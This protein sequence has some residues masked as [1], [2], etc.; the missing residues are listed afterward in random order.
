MAEH[1]SVVYSN[2]AKYVEKLLDEVPSG[3]DLDETIRTLVE[4]A[5]Q[6]L[7]N[8][9]G[10]PGGRFYKRDGA[11][12]QLQ[13]VFGDGL[14]IEDPPRLKADYPPV[15]VCCSEGLVYFQ[16]DDPRLDRELE[17]S[18][19]A[20][21]FAAIEV[22]ERDYLLAFDLAEG[23]NREET[24]VSLG[25]LRSSINQRVRQERVEDVF[26]EARRIQASL[27][28]RRMPS[29][30]SF[31]FAGRSDSVDR[32]GGDFYDFIPISKKI[33]G[34]TV[35]DVSGHGLPAALQ[36][37]DIYMGLRMGLG[38]DYKIVRTMERLSQIIHRSTLT[39]R[40]VSLFYGE[41]ELNGN[42]LYVNA[43]HPPPFHL[44]ADGEVTLLE[45][46]GVVMGPLPDATYERGY[47]KLGPGDLLV[48]YTDG[49]AE[50]HPE[51]SAELDEYGRDRLIE[52]V[53]SLRDSSA[54]DI[55]NGIFADVDK[56]TAGST[57]SD[58]RTV[59]VARYP[60]GC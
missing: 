38:R 36:V 17:D 34:L 22:G 7:R 45:E 29:Y 42:F 4:T 48:L 21:A 59:C 2:L 35:A 6:G 50:A 25:V 12:Y 46:G 52:C 41:L 53:K 18:L 27:L 1:P 51:G 56:F 32:V 58:D 31:E 11:D 49:I 37:R 5:A 3:D 57:A 19:G 44:A 20:S 33:L 55:V 30:G 40:F 43:G 15:D 47:V 14:Q 9:L 28:P 60:L 54:E 39:S 23:R 26:R 13:S 24:L 8:E 10:L 16:S